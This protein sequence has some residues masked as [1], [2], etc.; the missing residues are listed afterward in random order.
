MECQFW[1]A[2]NLPSPRIWVQHGKGHINDDQSALGD[3]LGVLVESMVAF[4]AS[5]EFT[6]LPCV[7]RVT[8]SSCGHDGNCNPQ[9]LR[10]LVPK[11]VLFT[12]CAR[13]V[14]LTCLGCRSSSESC[15]FLSQC[16]GSRP[17]ASL[18]AFY[19]LLVFH[20]LHPPC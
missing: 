19:F 6:F 16:S 5:R 11:P 1:K 18:S 2:Q 10:V 4:W 12:L 3:F 13:W 20:V 9:R 17:R 8:A 15:R 7:F 14:I